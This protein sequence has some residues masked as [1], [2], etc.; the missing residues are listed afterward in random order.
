MRVT[1]NDFTFRILQFTFH[2]PAEYE[3]ELDFA[4]ADAVAVP[5]ASGHAC[6]EATVV[7]EGAIGTPQVFD[8]VATG[9]CYYA[10]VL[11]RAVGSR[12]VI[13]EVEMGEDLAGEG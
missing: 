4:N 7:E 3:V 8:E 9:V 2:S 10:G 12:V 13:G 11:S 1:C 6:R 5:Q